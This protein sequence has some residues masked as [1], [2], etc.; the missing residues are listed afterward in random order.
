MHSRIFLAFCFGLCFLASCKKNSNSGSSANSSKLKMYIEESHVAGSFAL[1][2][3]HVSY[4]NDGRMTGMISPAIGIKYGYNGNTSF[5]TD[6]FENGSQTI[7]EIAYLNGN[8]LV[9]STFQY[10]NT[11]DTTTEGYAYSGS[12]LKTKTTYMYSD[13]LPY[14]DTREVFTYDGNGNC[15]KDVT[16]DSSGV[17]Q[18]IE[19]FTYTN[20]SFQL[21]E[22]PTY[23]PI[24]AKNLPASLALTD[25]QGNAMGSATF[26]YVFDGSGRVTKETQKADNGDY[27]IKT[28]VY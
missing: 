14:V 3:F 1:D 18:S 25:G 4:D 11:Q 16:S 27:V 9:D 17:V 20:K 12:Q 28:Y 19:T 7:H 8:K 10:N 22:N 2:S 6:L 15:V 26:A 23:Y 24:Q 21:L 5:T 13:G